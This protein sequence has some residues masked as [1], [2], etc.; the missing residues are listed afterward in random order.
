MK[1]TF[2][3]KAAGLLAVLTLCSGLTGC[4][5]FK[6]TSEIF[7]QATDII[8]QAAENVLGTET[9]AAETT[10]TETET[11]TT[12]A[13]KANSSKDEEKHTGTETGTN[14]DPPVSRSHK[15]DVEAAKEVLEQ[16][17]GACQQGDTDKIMEFSNITNLLTMLGEEIDEE[18]VRQEMT[19]LFSG[20][21]DFSIRGGSYDAQ[22]VEQFN[23]Y[24]AEMQDEMNGSDMNALG[25]PIAD[26]FGSLY[27]PVDGIC[28]FE[29][30]ATLDGEP[31][32]ET[33]YVVRSGDKWTLDM[34]ILPAMLGYI[35]RA[36]EYLSDAD[37]QTLYTAAASALDSMDMN[38]IDV[39]TL[40]G[41]LTFLPEDF[42]NVQHNENENVRTNEQIRQEF[43]YR[44]ADFDP[45][46]KEFDAVALYIENGVCICAAVQTKDAEGTTSVSVYPDLSEDV[47]DS[48]EDLFP[49]D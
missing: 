16:F 18:T 37:A 22:L 14:Q 42:V 28:S 24:I 7:D 35:D 33:L 44:L 17:L 3:E 31:E 9:S 6:Q 45:D 43:A 10:V 11:T 20:V 5:M 26:L 23:S 46:V 38:G 1:Y 49:D 19:E 30:T 13:K 40:D 27:Q 29:I 2:R 32:T 25:L 8:D 47:F 4:S 12:A 39:Q 21:T 36:E 48:L 15:Q 34:A 41:D